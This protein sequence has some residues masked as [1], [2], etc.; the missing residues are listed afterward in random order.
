MD[1]LQSWRGNCDIQILIYESSPDN[2]DIREISK[3]TDYVVAYSC[4]GNCTLREEKEQNKKL[5]LAAEGLTG[6]KAD[7][8]RVC[9]QVMNKVAS[10]RVISKQE[11]MVLL[12]DL[13]L[14]MCTET[15]T[16]VS[17]SRSKRVR[18]DSDEPPKKRSKND[19]K[20]LEVYMKRPLAH[21][22]Y[23]LHAYFHFVKNQASGDMLSK[24]Q[25]PHFMGVQGYPC[26]PVSQAYAK[27]VL[28]VYKPWYGDYPK[29]TDWKQEFDEF[30][31]SKHCPASA[32]MTY[33]RVMQRHFDKTK[34]CEPKSHEPKYSLDN[35]DPDD[36]N[37]LLLVG[38]NG[39]S[40]GDDHESHLLKNLERGIN[41][42][43]DTDPS[44]SDLVGY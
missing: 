15:V 18:A 24:H 8:K 20:F 3:V 35:A 6:D 14:T 25:I 19:E 33:D 36:A 44:V 42:E 34:F 38:L 9:K 30:I 21:I 10:K 12:A 4:K 13:A 41:Y 16:P 37:D 32:R 23:S 1:L 27:Q 2:I 28:L 26:F 11:T 43:W 40:D 22:E 31:N 17:I 5:I 39:H 7:V 29:F